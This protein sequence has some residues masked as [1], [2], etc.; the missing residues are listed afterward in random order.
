MGQRGEEGGQFLGV[1]G[2]VGRAARGEPVGPYAWY[3]DASVRVLGFYLADIYLLGFGLAV[4][5]LGALYVLLYRTRFGPSVRAALQDRTAASLVGVGVARGWMRCFGM[6]VGGRGAA[7]RR[8]TR[9]RIDVMAGTID[10]R[11]DT[12]TRPTAGMRAAIAAAEVELNPQEAEPLY[13]ESAEL[14]RTVLGETHPQ[15]LDALSNYGRFLHRKGDLALADSILTKVVTANRAA[16]GDRHA[17]V[18]HDLVNLA[19]VRIDQGNYAAAEK[20]LRTALDI[21]EDVLPPDHP[22]VGEHPDWFRR[23]PDGSVIRFDKNAAVL[24]DNKAEP[25]GTRIF[26]PV[27]RELRAKNHMKIISLAPEVL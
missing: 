12:V 1:A 8:C 14:L 17:Y 9:V 26:G 10:L 11:S 13:A 16:R 20:D 5:L 23:R 4:V 3:V 21:Y 25:V 6:C 27:P 18:G 2:V 22:Y 7:A 24:I 15:T 19:I